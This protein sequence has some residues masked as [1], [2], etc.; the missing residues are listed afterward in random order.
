M[1][2]ILETDTQGRI[3]YTYTT[4]NVISCKEEHALVICQKSTDTAVWFYE[5]VC[6]LIGTW[7]NTDV[8]QLKSANDWNKALNHEKMVRRNNSVTLDSYINT[9]ADHDLT[10]LH[11]LCCQHFEIERSQILELCFLDADSVESTLYWL[12]IQRNSNVERYFIIVSKT[13]ELISLQASGNLD[14][15]KELAEFKR[16]NL[17]GKSRMTEDSSV[18]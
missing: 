8:D 11:S 3:L 17:W 2:N 12:N 7:S 1:C 18:S 4:D 13:G 9:S 16:T 14:D 15:L 5:D 10:S 6:Y